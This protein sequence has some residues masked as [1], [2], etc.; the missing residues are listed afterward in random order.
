MTEMSLPPAVTGSL[1][2]AFILGGIAL[3]VR[4]AKG[5]TADVARDRDLGAIRTEM[6]RIDRRVDEE[7]AKV[8]AELSGKIADVVA[9]QAKTE[10]QLTRIVDDT[11]QL[12]RRM[13]NVMTALVGLDGK[14]GIRGE[15]RML[16]EDVKAMREKL[17]HVDFTTRQHTEHL[18]RI[19]R[20]QAALSEEG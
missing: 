3:L 4:N 12:L 14:N 15:V 20:A 13:D 8:R 5:E 7:V 11:S 2:V 18:A 9:H 6:H 1:I 17:L 16:T 10:L 19:D